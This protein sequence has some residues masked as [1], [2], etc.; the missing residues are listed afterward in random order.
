MTESLILSKW[1]K[2]EMTEDK[3]IGAGFETSEIL[4]GG[5]R[6]RK[7]ETAEG[8]KY[9]ADREIFKNDAKRVMMIFQ[10]LQEANLPTVAFAKVM[11][12]KENGDL[13][14]Y[15]TMEDLTNNGELELFELNP[16]LSFPQTL[17]I[18]DRTENSW[19]LKKQAVEALAI[20]HNNGIV[21]FHPGLSF[22]LR[23][24]EKPGV[25][26][27]GVDFK[28]VDFPNLTKGK[29]PKGWG[30]DFSFED[31]CY[32]DLQQLLGALEYEHHEDSLE[33]LKRHYKK[34]RSSGQTRYPFT[35]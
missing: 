20:M 17:D 2:G 15:L 28:I 7:F 19:A 34:V 8:A 22:V 6:R 25:G 31:E 10:N 23:T 12:K 18:L 9:Y 29:L 35:E 27:V 32:Q 13:K 24:I 3:Q 21:D 11:R 33:G 14:Y 16:Q 26:K 5:V 4:S 30:G 1:H